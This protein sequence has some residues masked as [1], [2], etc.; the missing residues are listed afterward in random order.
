MHSHPKIGIVTVTYNSEHVLPDF[1]QSLWAQTHENFI[2]YAVDNASKDASV[3][4]LR[5]EQDPRLRVVANTTN[6]GVAEGN[7][8]GI[9][10]ALADSCETV[11]LL[12]NDVEFPED[13][14]FRL[15]AG[16]SQ[17]A[18]EM[19]TGKMLYYE[20]NDTIWCAGGEFRVARFWA[21]VHYGLNQ[22]DQGQFNSPRKVTYTP[23]CCLLAKATVFERV[24]L[25]DSK[26]FV[27]TDDVDFLYRCLKAHISL[28]Y[29]PAALLY[30][31][32]SSL[33]GGDTSDFSVR[34]MT[35]NRLYFLRKHLSSWH[36][37]IWA[38]RT[39]CLAAPLRVLR[40]RESLHTFALKCRSLYEGW[41]MPCD[42]RKAEHRP[43]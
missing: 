21:V 20:P 4:L 33:T 37:A 28:W 17:H 9:R 42:S 31:K 22:Q 7:N 8:I 15:Q 26:Y 16:L 27:Y 29:L 43:A 39:L 1:F 23:T 6:V 30:H 19:T 35:R 10:A 24:G 36:A 41:T 12:N 18:C 5:A 11:L 3:A 2:L 38:L 32:V 40:R 25:M 14:L 13:L 34:F